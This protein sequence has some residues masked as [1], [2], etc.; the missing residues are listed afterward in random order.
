MYREFGSRGQI[1]LEIHYF[2]NAETLLKLRDTFTFCILYL[3]VINNNNAEFKVAKKRRAFGE[4]QDTEQKT[5]RVVLN[6]HPCETASCLVCS[7]AHEFHILNIRN[8]VMRHVFCVWP[9]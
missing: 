2:L 6:E 8:Y 1:D 7:V 9:A 4:L 5:S 3:N